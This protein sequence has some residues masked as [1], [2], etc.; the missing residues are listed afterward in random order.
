MVVV[1]RPY[2]LGL[3]VVVA[4]CGGNDEQGLFGKG[5]GGS[6]QGGAPSGGSAGVPSGGNAGTPSG[7]ASG[8]GGS[9]GSVPDGGGSGGS[10]ASGGA[11]G[12]G[13][14]ATG[15]APSGGTGGGSG[16]GTGPC[17]TLTCAFSAGDACCKAENVPLY[18]S[19][20][21]LSNPCKCTGILC[22]TLELKCDGPEDCSAG[23]VCCAERGLTSSTWDVV[24]CRETCK[25][26]SIGATRRELCHP[27]GKPCPAGAQC[28]VDPALPPGYATCSQ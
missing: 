8:S 24:E 13:T 10:V 12:G 18:C 1:A 20:Q 21:T 3:G 16:V 11:A 25:S 14:G 17:G 6:A 15:G 23:K 22:D 4:A 28:L 26:D 9:A 7:G 27:G 5:S 19:N 2:V